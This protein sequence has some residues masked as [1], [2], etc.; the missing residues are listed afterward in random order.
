M[1]GL[2]VDTGA[3]CVLRVREVDSGRVR[4]H[5]TTT[6]TAC[7]DF[8]SVVAGDQVGGRSPHLQA[9]LSGFASVKR[10]TSVIAKLADPRADR[11]PSECISG[12]PV[13]DF[14]SVYRYHAEAV[15]RFCLAQ[16]GDRAAAEDCA[17]DAFAA[18]LAAYERT[19]PSPDMV[20]PWLFRIARNSAVTWVRR[21][22]A[23]HR[24]VEQVRRQTDDQDVESLAALRADL[25]R[26]P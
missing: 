12:P 2:V 9:F 25:S 8:L 19:Q 15:Y 4:G 14:E 6:L 23:R 10:L 20:R 1:G 24:L 11:W 18:A 22:K 21:E 16:L 3:A 7:E 17:A 5:P 13:A 26:R